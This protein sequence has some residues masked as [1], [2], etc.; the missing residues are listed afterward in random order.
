[1]REGWK[2]LNVRKEFADERQDHNSILPAA[3]RACR[4]GQV[5]RVGCRPAGGGVRAT[6]RLEVFPEKAK[7]LNIRKQST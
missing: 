5:S 1:M 7:K 4:G 3:C 2:L 6:A